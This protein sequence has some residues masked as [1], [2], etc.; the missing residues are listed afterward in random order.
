M[1]AVIAATLANAGIAASKF[2]AFALTGSSSMLSEA[3]HSLA[4]TANELLLLLGNK[5]AAQSPDQEHQFGYGRLRY[6]YAFIVSIVLFLVGGVF[7]LLEGFHKFLHPEELTDAWV[8]IAVLGVSVALESW[9]WRTAMREARRSGIPMLRFI[10]RTRQP[11]LPV[12][13]L[14]DTGALIGL[15]FALVG[16]TMSAVTGDGRWDG[17]G[18]MGVGALLVVIALFLAFEMAS[19]LVGESAL[20]ELQE[21]IGSAAADSPD[22]VRVIN[23][24]TVHVGPDE[25]LVAMKL[26]LRGLLSVQEV[27]GAINDAERRIRIAVPSAT[28]VYLEPDV[29]EE[30]YRSRHHP[31]PTDGG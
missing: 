2:V 14:E 27:A 12:V 22:V 17:L 31:S 5:R 26:E 20:P 16:V 13:L 19:L 8:A 21:A 24:R 10:R 7:S 15:S 23:M 30:D 25:L 9:S 11:E 3:I 29:Y 28:Y 6:V 1:R 4:D 18:A